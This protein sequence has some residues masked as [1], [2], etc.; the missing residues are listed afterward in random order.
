DSCQGDSGGPLVIE[1]HGHWLQVGIVSWGKGCA[2]PYAYGIYTRLSSF[3]DWIE[4][5]TGLSGDGSQAEP[6]PLEILK[7]PQSVSALPG[8]P[9]V[10]T[11][12][13]S[14]QEPM[15][16]QWFLNGVAVAGA[17]TAS[18]TVSDVSPADAGSY[19][20][21]VNAGG[22][23]LLSDSAELTLTQIADLA[24]ALDQPNWLFEA[25]QEASSWLGQ[26][27]ESHDQVDAAHSVAIGNNQTA[28]LSTQVEGPGH[29]SFFWKVS[30]EILWDKL[31]FLVDGQVLASISGERRWEAFSTTLT[32]GKHLLQWIY[33]KD[34]WLSQGQDRGWVDQ[35][36]F[37]P[38]EGLQIIRSPSS[39]QVLHGQ[40]TTFQ[41]E[42]AGTAP[43]F[44][45]WYFNDQ[46]ILGAHSN[47]L[48]IAAAGFEQA[49]AYQ[50]A[51]ISGSDQ[52]M[53]E[54]A[55]LEVM[56]SGLLGQA[57]EQPLL[58]YV[59]GVGAE[60]WFYQTAITYDQ[61]DAAQ[62]G[63]VESN[64]ASVL[65]TSLLGPGKLKFFWKVSSEP[66]NDR[67]ECWL[68]EVL[69]STISG[70]VDWH[71]A[72]VA[73]PKGRHTVRWVYSKDNLLARGRD[74]AWLDQI[75]YLPSMSFAII[76]EPKSIQTAME[77][78]VHFLVE[79]VG[80]ETL[81]YQWFLDG[82]A[83]EGATKPIYQIESVSL[84]D[85]GEY[86]VA[87]SAG[88]EAEF[89]QGATLSLLKNPTLADALDQPDWDFT[90]SGDHGWE[91]ES[92]ITH[93]G[94]DAAHTPAIAD[95]QTA[96][97][98]VSL[99]GPGWLRFFWKVS[100]EK[101]WDVLECW[102]DHE[103]HYQISGEVD[104]ARVEVPIP[105]GSHEVSW[106]YR[107]DHY[108]S[109]GLD[110]AW[111]DAITFEP[112]EIE[113]ISL[114]REAFETRNAV[115]TFG[116]LNRPMSQGW[117]CRFPLLHYCL[118]HQLAI[119]CIKFLPVIILRDITKV[120]RGIFTSIR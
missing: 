113:Q 83:I 26:A 81:N 5:I 64:Q 22:Q 40:S 32:Q 119:P 53:S 60:A 41:V 86:T 4:G 23:E 114:Y 68:D 91:L 98:S 73:I 103:L 120:Y 95:N 79:A 12:T 77:Q 9:A 72:W 58:P 89:S 31:Q 85:E 104:W 50:V 106:V 62:S 63:A 74:A 11:V 71:A 115:I 59:T 90:A 96:A 28:S 48:D 100:S 20:V 56:E 87:I 14:G 42:A 76:Q 67:L 24:Q 80:G 65:S 16:Y 15:A 37:L 36:Q 33:Q 78:R 3:A 61:V 2:E 8:Q 93:D 84:L 116:S 35:V 101:E 111:L 30:C 34:D 47:T 19:T 44:Y 27:N 75:S 17:Q 70:E 94:I 45:Q 51:V 21:L 112:Q 7:Q 97:L 39:R 117:L 10:L 52:V 66:I 108:I 25:D 46:P 54:V 102:S 49:G 55:T 13:A 105:E 69:Q 92:A 109:E 6:I 118:R 99:Q 18:L 82:V 43:F 29:L 110:R 107:K 38:I 57:L 1:V 88:G